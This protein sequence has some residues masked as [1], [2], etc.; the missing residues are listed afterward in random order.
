[1]EVF[2]GT[3]RIGSDKLIAPIKSVPI[4][5]SVLCLVLF[6][7]SKYLVMYLIF[8]RAGPEPFNSVIRYKVLRVGLTWPSSGI[9]GLVNFSPTHIE[10]K[11]NVSLHKCILYYTVFINIC[12]L[13]PRYRLLINWCHC[14]QM[15][16]L[17]THQLTHSTDRP[18][19]CEF[20]GCDFSFKTK[21]SLKRHTRRH[22]GQDMDFKGVYLLK[23]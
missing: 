17:K 6:D 18:Y 20:P 12:P 8:L 9:Y 7:L 15:F 4:K 23:W 3:D 22:T 2:G 16:T 1:M 19:V 21:G 14:F 11:P 13:I 10:I 5:Q